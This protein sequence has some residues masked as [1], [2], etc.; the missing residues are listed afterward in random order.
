MNDLSVITLVKNR[1]AHLTRLLQSVQSSGVMP[2]EVIIVDMSSTPIDQAA[3]DI[4]LLIVPLPTSGL[5]LASARNRGAEAASGRQLLFMDV[6]CIPRRNLVAS[7]QQSLTT[8]DHLVCAEIRYLGANARTLTDETALDDASVAHPHRHFPAS[9]MRQES[10]AGLFWS[11]LFGIRRETFFRLGGFDESY[12]GYGAEDTDFGFRARDAGL[13]LM[14]IGGTGAFHQYHG[15]IDPPLQH[16]SDI[17]RNANR[18]FQKWR[19]WPMQDWLAAFEDIGLIARHDDR[20]VLQRLPTPAEM[21]QATQPPS[22]Y[23]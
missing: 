7:I 17:V 14:F 18:F 11:L 4:P 16:V 21:Q 9:G 10:N 3:S 13:P 19:V 2:H 20:I 23:F 5:P 12:E 15:V 22:V 1:E 8:Y 6:D